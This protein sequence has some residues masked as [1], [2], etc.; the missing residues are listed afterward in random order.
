MSDSIS[1][2]IEGSASDPA[3]L[4]SVLP[5]IKNAVKEEV[6]SEMEQTNQSIADVKALLTL[7]MSKT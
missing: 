3:P 1:Y 2:F 5:E 7:L 6:R 4:E